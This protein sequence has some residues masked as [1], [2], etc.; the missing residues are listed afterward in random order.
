MFEQYKQFFTQKY[1]KEIEKFNELKEKVDEYEKVMREDN[2][3]E[4]YKKS[5]EGL[6]K[7]YS[8]FKRGKEYKEE[9]EKLKEDFKNKLIKYE[10]TYNEYLEIKR[11]ASKISIYN[12]QKKLEQL[13]NANSL[14]DLKL[15]EETAQEAIEK[16]NMEEI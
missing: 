15:T 7:K 1:N 3:E 12:I 6:K 2:S 4:E 8:I 10:Q 5:L 9:V 16:A 13:M 14:E 11:E